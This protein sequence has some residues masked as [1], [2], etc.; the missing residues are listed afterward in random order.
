MLSNEHIHEEIEKMEKT[1][2]A[3]DDDVAKAIIKGNVLIIKLLHNIRTNMTEVMKAQGINL[4][5]AKTKVAP[6]L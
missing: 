6:E 2:E 1:R 4:I 5:K 3:T